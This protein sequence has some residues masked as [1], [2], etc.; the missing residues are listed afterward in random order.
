[1][2]SSLYIYLPQVPAVLSA[3]SNHSIPCLYYSATDSDRWTQCTLADI[4]PADDSQSVF[5]FLPSLHVLSTQIKVPKKQQKHLTQ[6]LPFLCEDKLACDVEDVH[7]AAGHIRGEDVAVRIIQRNL[8]ETLL[9]K[10]RSQSISPK[11]I[12]SDAEPLF[13]LSDTVLWLDPVR[14]LLIHRQQGLT[15]QASQAEHLAALLKKQA[16]QE[17]TL[18]RDPR[19]ATAGINLTLEELRSQGCTINETNLSAENLDQPLPLLPAYTA[20]GMEI[21]PERY[22]NLLTGSYTPTRKTAHTL[23][24]QPLAWVASL[25]IGLNLL[26]LLASGVYFELRAHQF[27]E[28]SVLLYR[29]YFP[30]DKRIVNIRTQT[31]SHLD[32]GSY[33]GDDHFLSLLG[34]I[35]PSWEQHKQNLQLKSLRYNSQRGEI[36]IDIESQ[37]ISQLDHLQQ[38]LGSRAELLSANEDSKNG[39]RGRIKFQGGR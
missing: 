25:F 20:Q 15:V 12:Y 2:T 23:R 35:L 39:A 33:N 34:Q 14:G 9:L 26:Y 31:K 29:E 4:T 30:Q 37:N 38:T 32:K 36:L 24:W 22:V 18:F 19:M 16:P 27:Q 7:L 3:T 11:G 1:M 28:N 5:L 17:V 13:T 6:I 10:L 21:T 8:L